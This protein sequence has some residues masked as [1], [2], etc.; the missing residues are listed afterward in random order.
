M[1]EAHA[2]GAPAETCVQ[3]SVEDVH[4]KQSRANST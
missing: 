2:D 1:N 3:T 4:P